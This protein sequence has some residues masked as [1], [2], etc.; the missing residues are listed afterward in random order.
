M[1]DSQSRHDSSSRHRDRR[2]HHRL[3]RDD[4]REREGQKRDGRG[5]EDRSPS[6]SRS[7]SHSHRHRSRSPRR[8]ETSAERHERHRAERRRER[9]S[10]LREEEEAEARR[11]QAEALFYAGDEQQPPARWAKKEEQERRAGLTPEQARARDEQRRRDAETE[12]ALLAQRRQQREQDAQLR[13]E[14]E[15][16]LARLQQDYGAIEWVEK[17][18]EFSLEQARKRAAIRIRENRAKPIDLMAMNLRWA[19]PSRTRRSARAVE[20]ALQASGG[21]PIP[22]DEMGD[23]DEDD[24]AGLEVDLQMPDQVFSLLDLGETE[25]LK[26]DI[27]MYLSLE[28]AGQHLAFWKALQLLCDD[29]LT[30]LRE[31]TTPVQE[32]IEIMLAPKTLDELTGLRTSVQDKLE[33][34][35]PI[36]MEYWLLLLRKIDVYI[37]RAQLRE[38]H[39]QVLANRIEFLRR[40]QRDIALAH[41]RTLPTTSGPAESTFTPDMEPPTIEERVYPLLPIEDQ[42]PILDPD[43]DRRLLELARRA[44]RA[45]AFVPMPK[46]EAVKVPKAKVKATASGGIVLEEARGDDSDYEGD[47]ELAVMQAEAA[48]A[49]DQEP[50]DLD[51]EAFGQE[52]FNVSEKVGGTYTWENKYRPRKPRFFNRVATGFEWNKYNQTHYDHDNPPPKVVQGYKFNI[53]YPDLI[54]PLHAPTYEI[55]RIPGDDETVLLVFKAGPPYEDIAF[56]V[57]NKPWEMGRRKGFRNSFERGVLQ[58]YFNFTKLRYRK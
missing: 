23:D 22:Q 43:D 45:Q 19:E 41:Q 10:R 14:E 56:R 30:T 31:G 7:R 4:D 12:I 35:E 16:R 50:D 9:R 55:R 13:Q 1:S 21:R 20:L 34:G 32:K 5:R 8:R 18:D 27:G 44:V 3:R 53:F 25:E 46:R 26:G 28:K 17:E 52:T 47:E 6:Y 29:R 57:V 38:T 58:L 24:E 42:L 11:K 15:S 48:R 54:D 39:K 36:D 2:H 51:V 33:S 37:S 49:M 40:K